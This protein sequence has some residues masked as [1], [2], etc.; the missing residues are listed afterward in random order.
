[1][2]LPDALAHILL[3]VGDRKIIQ[4]GF[5]CKVA[6]SEL[7]ATVLE[8]M[9]KNIYQTHLLHCTVEG[10]IKLSHRIDG[11]HAFKAPP[12]H[13]LTGFYKICQGNDVQCHA[14]IIMIAVAG[15]VSFKPPAC[16][17]DK[18]LFYFALKKLLILHHDL[19]HLSFACDSFIDQ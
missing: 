9:T 6:Y 16:R 8:P 14:P 12:C 10:L 2:P 3:I 19:H 17:R 4:G 15:I 5:R 18:V 13:G 7:N 11:A 1:M